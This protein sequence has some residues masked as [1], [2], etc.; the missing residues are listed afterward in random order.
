MESIDII[1]LPN[2]NIRNIK[3]LEIP[4]EKRKFQNRLSKFEKAR[5][6]SLRTQ[7]LKNGAKPLINPGENNLIY[8]NNYYYEIAT[9]ELKKKVIPLKIRRYHQDS[10]YEVWNIK[11]LSII[12]FSL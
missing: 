12:D 4:A 5:I 1:E 10:K 2:E 6:L 7:Q 3:E 9:I 8:N 11:E